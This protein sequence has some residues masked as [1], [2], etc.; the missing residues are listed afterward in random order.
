MASGLVQVEANKLLDSSVKGAAYTA[1][2]T[3][4]NMRLVTVIGSATAAGT[5]VSNTG[6]STYAAQSTASAW[7]SA[8]SGSITNSAGA[9]SFTN[10]PACTVVGIE[11]WDSAGSPVRRWWGNLA[12]NKTV[13]AGDTL[14]FATSSITISLV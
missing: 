2:T 9:L 13:G 1:G 11:L 10:M 5:E 12:V 6:G 4:I 3:P 7:G 14:S 8:A